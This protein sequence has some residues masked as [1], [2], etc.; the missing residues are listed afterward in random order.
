[1]CCAVIGLLGRGERAR[2]TETE[3]SAALDGQVPGVIFVAKNGFGFKLGLLGFDSS[4]GGAWRRRGYWGFDL[5]FEGGGLKGLKLGFDAGC[6]GV[7]YGLG[8]GCRW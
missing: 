6:L 7:Y 1:M 8:N 3:A 4:V 2:G 5:S